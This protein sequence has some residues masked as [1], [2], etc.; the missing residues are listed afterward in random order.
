MSN[1][2]RVCAACGARVPR[3]EVH[4]NRYSQYICRPCHSS[5]VRA[6]GRQGIRHALSKVPLVVLAAVGVV[7]VMAM[8]VVLALLAGSLH[9]YSNGG[10]LQDLKDVFRSL[11]QLA[12]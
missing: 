4:K 2:S 9:G 6:V 5:G 11:N 3:W 1:D 10:M 12:R 8:L 7:L